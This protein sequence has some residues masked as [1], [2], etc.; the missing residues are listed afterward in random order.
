[1][2]TIDRDRL[3][4]SP[5]LVAALRA[6]DPGYQAP[7]SRFPR[8]S[9]DPMRGECTDCGRTMVSQP[10]YRA[11][12]RWRAEGFVRHGAGRLCNSCYT[13]SR[14]RSTEEHHDH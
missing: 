11:Q 6:A 8:P 12:R 4:I 14:K 5:N 10:V 9:V 13:G 3:P 1:M 2:T 7:T